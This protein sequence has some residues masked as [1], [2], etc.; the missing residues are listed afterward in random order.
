V[1]DLRDGGWSPA[2]GVAAALAVPGWRAWRS[3]A[4]WQARLRALQ[5]SAH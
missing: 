1:L 4:S 5:A 3:A 2:A